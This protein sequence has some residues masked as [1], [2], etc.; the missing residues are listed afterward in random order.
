M[1]VEREQPELTIPLLDSILESWS[2]A[3]PDFALAIEARKLR[4][5]L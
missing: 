3:D 5:R 4:E 2:K 1:E